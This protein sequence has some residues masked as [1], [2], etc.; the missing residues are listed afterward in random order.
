MGQARQTVEKFFE[1][2]GSGKIVDATELFDPSCITVMPSGRLTQA[3]HEG[4]ARA[5]KTGLPDCSMTVDHVVEKD[6]EVVV[7]GHFIGTHTGDL[8]SAGGT[9]P[10]SGNKLHLRF[11]DYFKVVGGKIVDHQTVFDQVEMLTQLGAMPAPS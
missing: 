4:M 5:F 6:D 2:F 10:A 9:L 1:L 3:E 7:L 8:Q 11:M